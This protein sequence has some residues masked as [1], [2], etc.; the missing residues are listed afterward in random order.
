MGFSHDG[1]SGLVRGLLVLGKDWRSC[2]QIGAEYIEDLDGAVWLRLQ[3]DTVP[4]FLMGATVKDTGFP[5]SN[6][7]RGSVIAYDLTY[8]VTEAVAITAT[9]SYASR[10]ERPGAIGGGLA[11][12][13][14]F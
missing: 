10:S 7:G 4:P 12:S 8:P 1:F 9:I 13:F 6:I 14:E 5:G 2:V 11:T 3:W